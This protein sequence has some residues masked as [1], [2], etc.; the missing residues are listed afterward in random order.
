MEDELWEFLEKTI[1]PILLSDSSSS[2][3]SFKNSKEEMSKTMSTK[4]MVLCD[5]LKQIVSS[6]KG[7]TLSEV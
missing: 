6:L 7:S 3:H 5:Y 1:T 2:S 4:K